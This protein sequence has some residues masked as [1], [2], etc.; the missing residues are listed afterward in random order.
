MNSDRGED[1]RTVL[2]VEAEDLG[3]GQTEAQPDGNDTP[4]GGPGD[5]IEMVRHPLARHP[6]D[7]GEEGG[8]EHTLDATAIESQNPER[9][10]MVGFHAAGFS[11]VLCSMP[12]PSH[13]PVALQIS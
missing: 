11:S 8:G 13:S 3:C 12:P 6:L 9:S 4:G 1:R 5:Q 2:H 7:L 10:L